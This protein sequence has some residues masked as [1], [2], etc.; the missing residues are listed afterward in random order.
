MKNN[1]Q[2]PDFNRRDFLKGGSFAALMMLMGGVEITAQDAGKT[3][4]LTKGDPN[5][6]EKPPG[7]P[8]KCGVIGLGAWGREIMQAMSRL[9]NAPIAAICDTYP[10]S[11]RRA[12]ESAP[13]AEKYDD[14]RKL[15][16]N[17]EV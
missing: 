11:L 10:S 13:K 3:L 6:K 15:L 5:F 16:E 9:P 1:D 7:P 8:V 2:L 12:E 4:P 14:Y 17:K